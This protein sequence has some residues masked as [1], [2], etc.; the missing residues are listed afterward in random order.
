MFACKKLCFNTRLTLRADRRAT[1][2]K[3]A[4]GSSMKPDHFCLNHR[5]A[6]RTLLVLT[7]MALAWMALA[8]LGGARAAWAAPGGPGPH[9]W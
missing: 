7:W 3:E 6:L 1:R 4:I 9:L 8:A 5:H 2:D